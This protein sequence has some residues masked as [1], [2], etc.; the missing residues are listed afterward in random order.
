MI[1]RKLIQKVRYRIWVP[2]NITKNPRELASTMS[3]LFPLRSD[4]KWE[5]HF[6]LLN[7]YGLITGD[8]SNSQEVKSRFLFFDKD[9]QRL[10]EKLVDAPQYGRTT[11]HI[12]ENFHS[13]VVAASTFAVI[14]EF[15]DI[16]QAIGDS[17]VTERGYT[18]YSNCDSVIRGYVHGNFDAIA[19]HK[20]TVEPVGN[21][22]IFPRYYLV[23]HPLRGPARYEFF[24]SNPTRGA[25]KVRVQHK[26]GEGP[27]VDIYRF[28][29]HSLGSRI[30]QVDKHE[31]TE[32]FIRVKSRL[33]LGRPVV[34]R[35][36]KR[37]LDVF[38]G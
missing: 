9:G 6:E 30:F 31:K 20:G 3:D 10:G 36:A 7:L 2:R 25:V 21:R 23:Q 11:I 22:G 17:Y 4:S 18:G 14:H 37:S 27:W 24:L 35:L 33:Y 13:A 38:H 28:K 16:R 29:L 12:D 5:T 19:Y 1:F 8:N 15:P 26:E 32:S 34:F